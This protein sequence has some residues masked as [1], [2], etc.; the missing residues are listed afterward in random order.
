[1]MQFGD[2]T[3][4]SRRIGVS[5]LNLQICSELGAEI[6]IKCAVNE[7]K[8]AKSPGNAVLSLQTP[9]SSCGAH[10]IYL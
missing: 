6:A 8:A 7:D 9:V 4:I 2:A 10:V 3:L 1:M 5:F